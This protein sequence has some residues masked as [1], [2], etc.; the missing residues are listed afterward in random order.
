MFQARSN[1]AQGLFIST[2]KVNVQVIIYFSAIEIDLYS[3]YRKNLIAVDSKQKKKKREK[4]KSDRSPHSF[5]RKRRFISQAKPR[6]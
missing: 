1:P 5:T 4:K 6:R 2:G 3:F